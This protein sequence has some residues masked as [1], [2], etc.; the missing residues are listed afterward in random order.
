MPDFF[1]KHVCVSAY[2]FFSPL[3]SDRVLS[4]SSTLLNLGLGGGFKYF[5]NVHPYLGFHDPI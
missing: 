4:F 2:V 3:R 1:C 5:C